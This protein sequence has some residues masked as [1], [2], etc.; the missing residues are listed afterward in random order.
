MTVYLNSAGKDRTRE[1]LA[2]LR[3]QRRY[4]DAMRMRFLDN[5][6]FVAP[7]KN[8]TPPTPAAPAV[9]EVRL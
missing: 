2:Y 5:V 4:R 8:W 3:A 6:S 9:L 7:P 1:T